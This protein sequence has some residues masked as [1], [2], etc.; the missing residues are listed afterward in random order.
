LIGAILCGVIFQCGMVTT[1]LWGPTTG[2]RLIPAVVGWGSLLL[3]SGFNI[4]K[5]KILGKVFEDEYK[6][7]G[8]GDLHFFKREQCLRYAFFLR[9][10][11]KK[12]YSHDDIT[13]LIR[14]AETVR[15]PE[16]TV[17]ID[18]HP[19]VIFL[20]GLLAGLSLDALKQPENWNRH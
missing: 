14:F 12:P 4:R 7:Y 17:R 18:Q 20:V 1:Y 16:P 13:R 9:G 5:I 2:T 15:K 11:T 6:Q 19:I 8:I 10:L 3:I